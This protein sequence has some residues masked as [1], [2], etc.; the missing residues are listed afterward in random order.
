MLWRNSS[1]AVAAAAVVAAVAHPRDE[2]RETR[3]ERRKKR[4]EIR[5]KIHI[6]IYILV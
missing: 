5:E 2:R 1:V 4:D 6:Y 3:D